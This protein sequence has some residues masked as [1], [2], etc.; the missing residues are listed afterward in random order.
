MFGLSTSPPSPHPLSLSPPSPSTAFCVCLA[1]PTH[2]VCLSA[3]WR[4]VA[5]GENQSRD[6]RAVSGQRQRTEARLHAA[7]RCVQTAGKRRCML[8]LSAFTNLLV[9]FRLVHG[10]AVSLSVSVSVSV[11]HCLCLSLSVTVCLSVCLSLLSL[12]IK[13]FEFEFSLSVCLSLFLFI[14][15]CVIKYYL[16]SLSLPVI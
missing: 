1:H 9:L 8:H 6:R 2:R 13:V 3:N 5:R 14:L 7:I 4:L 16:L 10:A 15:S 11:S 12:S